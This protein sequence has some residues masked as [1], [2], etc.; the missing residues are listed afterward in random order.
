MSIH[1]LWTFGLDKEVDE[2][3]DTL[4][5][6]E[7]EQSGM[8]THTLPLEDMD[9]NLEVVFETSEIGLIFLYICDAFQHEISKSSD[10]RK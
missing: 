5:I 4:D 9:A 1:E 6:S 7:D 8:W 2:F 10:V 3:E